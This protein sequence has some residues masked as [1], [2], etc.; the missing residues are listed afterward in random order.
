MVKAVARSAVSSV[1]DRTG[2]VILWTDLVTR[3]VYMMTRSP[4]VKA[5]CSSPT[6]YYKTKK[7][8]LWRKHRNPSDLLHDKEV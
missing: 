3:A 8:N 2:L 4:I 6:A 1:W 7:Y 5:V